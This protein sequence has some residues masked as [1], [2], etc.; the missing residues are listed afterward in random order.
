[1]SLDEI[2]IAVDDLASR[3]AS[4]GPAAEFVDAEHAIL[5]TLSQ[6][7]VV[8]P[9][10]V[11]SVE[12]T[13]QALLSAQLGRRS[14]LASALKASQ[15][16]LDQMSLLAGVALLFIVPAVAIFVYR[17]LTKPDL[18]QASLIHQ[19]DIDQRQNQ[20]RGILVGHELRRIR[21]EID[22]VSGAELSQQL[23]E[24]SALAGAGLDGAARNRAP[25][26]IRGA[27]AKAMMRLDSTVTIS[28]DTVL[29][30]ADEP[31][32]VTMLGA[33]LACIDGLD[34]PVAVIKEH[35]G[36]AEVSLS[37]VGTIEASSIL[38][39]PSLWD[40]AP[41][42]RVE[43]RLAAARS[44]AEASG[45]RIR[46][47]SKS[48]RSGFKIVMPVAVSDVGDIEQRLGGESAAA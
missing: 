2:R 31:D 4:P 46:Q 35:N 7:I 41:T 36:N 16:R 12:N 42:G 9:Q 14:D 34:D 44:L 33:L 13:F 43:S 28:G 8:P 11:A 10:Q 47:V 26:D 30:T 48:G 27:I 38:D 37:G 25:V 24:L 29:T 45:A 18:N 22:R 6:G 23:A 3:N 5:G 15:D 17:G 40:Q 32:L 39:G 20:N 21:A 19:A 1:M